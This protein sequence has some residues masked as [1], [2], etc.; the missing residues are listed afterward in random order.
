[1]KTVIL[2]G[3]LGTR[4]SEETD[5]KPK[6]M[7]EIGG[8][9]IIWHIMKL[10]SAHGFD[11]FVVCLGYKG[12]LIKEYF[13]NY[14]L[15]QADV[16][17]DLGKNEVT[18]QNAKAEKWKINLIDTGQL[19][20]TGGRLKRVADYV[21]ADEEFFLTYGDA[22]TDLD[23]KATL[24]QHRSQKK[25]ATLTAVRPPARFGNLTLD[26]LQVRRFA[27]KPDDHNGWIN[28]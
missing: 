8:W 18:Y 25:L 10:Y 17:I 6:P 5:L 21:G 13:Y 4:L 1:M 9:P 14:F 16:S 7:V 24:M 11:E 15:H 27:E 26:G 2:A 23:I 3:G 22:V 12:Y 20:M 28:G 19:T